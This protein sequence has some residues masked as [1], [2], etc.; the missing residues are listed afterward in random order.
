MKKTVI[1]FGLVGLTNTA[2]GYA[3]ILVA[4][5]LG[6]GDYLANALGYGLS[7]SAAYLLHRRFTFQLSWQSDW[8]EQLR[9]AITAALSFGVNIL[10]LWA[11][12]KMGYGE[13]PFAQLCAMAAYSISFFI[14]AKSW[15]FLQQTGKT[16][17]HR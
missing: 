3:I 9:F 14:L 1:R 4:I 5:L 16:P 7:L 8:S 2:I 6:A 12:R 10:V 15:V 13:N 11:A 17:M